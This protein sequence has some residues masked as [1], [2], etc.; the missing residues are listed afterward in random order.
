MLR[1]VCGVHAACMY[2]AACRHASRACGVRCHVVYSVPH[3]WVCIVHVAFSEQGACGHDVHLPCRMCVNAVCD[4]IVASSIAPCL[5]CA[6][7]MWHVMRSVRSVRCM[8]CV[9]VFGV[10]VACM[11]YATFLCPA[12]CDAPHAC[13]C[14]DDVVWGGCVCSMRHAACSQ[15]AACLWDAMCSKHLACGVHVRSDVHAV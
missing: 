6:V 5:W 3:L 4:M 14:C 9:S 11:V 15:R 13:G 7:F 2:P 12:A 1:E 8:C 10:H